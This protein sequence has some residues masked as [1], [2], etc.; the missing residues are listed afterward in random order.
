MSIIVDFHYD[1]WGDN[2]R[3]HESKLEEFESELEAISD[4]GF[5]A[6]HEAINERVTVDRVIGGEDGALER[7]TAAVERYVNERKRQDEITKLKKDVAENERWFDNLEA[8]RER[9]FLSMYKARA[10]LIEL[11]EE[12][13]N[14]SK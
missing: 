2:G 3:Y 11:G 10:R 5:K 14:E 9:R 1:Y 12:V 6:Y 13:V 8:E 4:L 7:I